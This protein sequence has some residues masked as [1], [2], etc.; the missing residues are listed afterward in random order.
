MWL[1]REKELQEE[2]QQFSY[3]PKLNKKKDFTNYNHNNNIEPKKLNKILDTNFY[4][5]MHI[6]D[7]NKNKK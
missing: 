7:M 2:E 3:K 5:R 6:F 4:N 1:Q